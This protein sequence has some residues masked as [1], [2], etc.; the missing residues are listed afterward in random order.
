MVHGK[1]KRRWD[2]AQTPYQRLRASGVLREEQ[3]TRLAQL[4]AATN[5]RQLR[6]DIYRAIA[7]L[8]QQIDQRKEA[9]AGALV[10]FL[11]E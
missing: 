9:A 1:L 7:Q 5:P 4:Y 8:W 10:T 6:E 3:E 11:N 2:R